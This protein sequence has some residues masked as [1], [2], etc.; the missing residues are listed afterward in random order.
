MG[1][2][3]IEKDNEQFVEESTEALAGMKGP[4]RLALFSEGRDFD[5]AVNLQELKAIAQMN[6]F[7]MIE[8]G[9]RLIFHKENVTHGE[10]IEDLH[11]V[12]LPKRTACRYMS[13]A[14]KLAGLPSVKAAQLTM[15]KAYALAE[16]LDDDEISLLETKG[17]VG[18]VALDEIDRMTASEL[19]KRL[20]KM[21]DKVGKK[22]AEIEGLEEQLDNRRATPHESMHT[23]LTKAFAGIV[24][25]CSELVRQIERDTGE[26]DTKVD[27]K[28][29][30]VREKMYSAVQK[31]QSEIFRALKPNLLGR[32]A[33]EKRRAS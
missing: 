18:T 15:S 26:L 22:D 32:S 24:L 1:K 20:R 3:K 28:G 6:A 23:D 7:C 12:G 19:R 9:K 33:E 11:E 14:R 29:E 25:A 13:T 16:E 17:K 31:Q 27:D 30:T 21:K 2:S 4:L 5:R 8:A 10:F